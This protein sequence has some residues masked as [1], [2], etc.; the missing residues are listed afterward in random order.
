MNPFNR[1]GKAIPTRISDR[2]A[3]CAGRLG[4]VRH[5]HFGARLCSKACKAQV[6]ARRSNND[7]TKRWIDFLFR[8][9][10]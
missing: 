3:H 2:C 10:R 9:H 1:R 4:L 5:R 6:I 8:A 7:Q